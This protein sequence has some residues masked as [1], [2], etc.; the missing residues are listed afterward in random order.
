MTNRKSGIYKITNIDN[1]KSYIGS[2][3]DITKRAYKHLFQL[4]NNFHNNKHLQNAYNKHG[5]GAFNFEIIE[6]CETDKLIILEQY[7]IDILKPEY[8]ICKIAYSTLGV[9]PSEETRL[10]MSK[11]QKG[12]KHTEESKVKM[13]LANKGKK[14]SE[15]HKLSI[16]KS[17]KRRKTIIQY[18]KQGNFIKEWNSI[19]ET[20][21]EFGNVGAVL[22]GKRKTC[23]GYI[24]KYKIN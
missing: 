4:R 8:N 14:L 1:D 6:R 21:K 20:M 9:I 23:G 12:R 24:W 11:S 13:S 19:L 17:Q 22:L 10:K 7:Y 16:S 2:S 3:V 15:E 5:E 18:D